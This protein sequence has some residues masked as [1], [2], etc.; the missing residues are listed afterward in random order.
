MTVSW[1]IDPGEYLAKLTQQRADAIEH[2]IENL[3]EHLRATAQ[4][5]MQENARWQD[6]T[7]HAREG[8]WAD[9]EHVVRQSLT[10]L[11]SHD[12]TLDYVWFLEYAHAGRFE[13]LS[14]ASDHF[15]PLLY[16]GVLA[17]LRKYSDY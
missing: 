15:W 9:V 17:I 7:R 10:L 13:I 5:W 3:M 16:Q 4:V 1:T 12:V 6:Q 8:L 14:S 11:L 2:D